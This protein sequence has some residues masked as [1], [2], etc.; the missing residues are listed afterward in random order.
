MKYFKTLPLV[1]QPDFNGNNVVVNNLMA[2]GKLVSSLS[3]NVMLFYQYD[4]KEGDTPEN[5]AYRY[6]NDMN[7]YWMIMYA[8][9][10]IDPQWSWPLNNNQF[11]LYLKNKYAEAAGGQDLAIAYALSTV[12]HYE[13][14]IS[15]SDTN[16]LQ[17][18]TIRV[19][20]DEDTYNNLMTNTQELTFDN[21]VVVTETIDKAAISIYDNEVELNE[22]KRK[23]NLIKAQYVDQMEIQLKALLKL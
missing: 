11:L 23:I 21:G 19:Q 8:N 15:T 6:Y 16:N 3:T 10:I 18:Q 12:D 7:R 20:I 5:I 1:S 22:N 4:I 14:I 2:R 13:K 17:K 9:N